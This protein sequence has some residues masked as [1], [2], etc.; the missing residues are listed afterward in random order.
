M[1]KFTKISADAFES[2]QFDAGLLLKTFDPTDPDEPAD[3][4][5]IC[6]TTGG[7][8]AS[9]V[10][11]YSDLGE[12]V[13]NC[14]NNMKELKILESWEAK[15][16]CTALDVTPEVIRLSLGAADIGS[17][18]TN[19]V[20]AR[21]DLSQSD[22]DDL[23]LVCDRLDG[24]FVAVHL[25]NA[26]STGGFKLQTTKKG[27][28]QVSLEFTGHVS[29]NAQDVVPMEF[30]SYEGDVAPSVTLNKSTLALTVGNNETLTAS[31]V[32]VASSVSWTSSASSV[33]S[34]N[35]SG[36]VTASQAGTATITAKITVDG[37]DYTDTCAV[38][39]TAS[40]A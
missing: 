20:T 28:G 23:W 21:M 5:I 11:T 35:S 33:A 9:L 14:P 27:K 38:T 29:I 18:N 6:A 22:F 25:L 36:K 37:V 16:S 17:Q 10:A 40:Q 4:D 12:D 31:V 3:A 8:S 26:L 24:G 1:G 7:I 2:M 32:P 39:V 13:D 34:V 15:L 30:Y 19:S